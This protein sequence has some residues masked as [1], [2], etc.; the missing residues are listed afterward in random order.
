MNPQI[1]PCLKGWAGDIGAVA[2]ARAIYGKVHRAPADYRWFAW[3]SGFGGQGPSPLENGLSLGIEDSISSPVYCWRCSPGSATA[4]KC[5]PSRAF[6]LSGRP[7]IIE[8]QILSIQAAGAEPPVALAFFLLPQVIPL[9]DD[10]W[11]STFQDV[12]WRTKGYHLSLEDFPCP[13]V[14]AAEFEARL[15]Q[16]VSQLLEAVP[17]PVLERFYAQL[18]A[19]DGTA[20]LAVNSEL[21]PLALAA[22]LL[23]LGRAET[24]TIGI[25]GGIPSTQ[26]S[27]QRL[28]HWRA[29]AHPPAMKLGDD[30]PIADGYRSAA[31]ELVRKL[32]RSYLRNSNA[33]APPVVPLSKSG[34][35]LRG[36]LE[37]EER[38][39]APGCPGKLSLRQ[40]GPLAAVQDE[41]EAEF[42]RAK[43]QAFVSGVQS[44]PGGDERRHLETKADLLKALLIALCPGPKSLKAVSVPS[45]GIPALLFASRIESR[46]WSLFAQYAEAGFQELA[47][48][49]LH[50]AVIPDF[51]K[52]V[53]TW[54]EE[55]ATS[56]EC[57][58]QAYAR[59]ALIANSA[60]PH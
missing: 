34:E 33:S 39:L 10:I 51:R 18:L 3:S 24:E 11:W 14:T 23:P 5:Y 19:G 40:V 48:Q 20:L 43:V 22:L 8:K 13:A 30:A 41:E 26:P 28:A 45:G 42:L 35:W 58:V 7:A 37:S 36:F 55:V 57:G 53:A 16:G 9:D 6:D 25:A 54:L 52:E 60:M 38:W 2:A 31:A 1:W 59:Q 47:A 44:Q 15:D 56:P 46:D 29:V 27:L 49:S 32:E 4:V 21:P 17:G 12:R 50:E